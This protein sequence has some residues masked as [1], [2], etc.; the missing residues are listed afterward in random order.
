MHL[1]EHGLELFGETIYV[2]R[3]LP[4]P[5]AGLPRCSGHTLHAESLSFE[6]P[7]KGRG[8]LTLRVEPPAAYKRIRAFLRATS[9]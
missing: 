3:G 9:G 8:K 6:H 5:P 7:R 4:E 1:L 2:A